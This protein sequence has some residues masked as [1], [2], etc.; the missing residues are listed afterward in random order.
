MKKKYLP[1][2]LEISQKK[3]LMIGPG[4]AARE[5][6]HSLS[7][8][9]KTVTVISSSFH[10]DFLNKSWLQLISR[11]YQK[12]DLESFDIVYVG[13]NDKEQEEQIFEEAQILQQE[14]KN[15]LL[16]F[17][18]SPSQ[19]DFISPSVLL[20]E[21]FAVFISSYGKNPALVKR[22]RQELEKTL[23]TLQKKIM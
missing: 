7:Q 9:Q 8:V 2:L 13:I 10:E 12:G 23:A 4:L 5:K 18:A 3:I 20:Q 22:L 21:Q 16:N 19:S 11:K 17:L 1:L 15:I 6:L 14:G